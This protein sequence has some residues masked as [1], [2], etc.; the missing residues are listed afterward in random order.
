MG[1]EAKIR[2]ERERERE[3]ESG[4]NFKKPKNDKLIIFDQINL[5]VFQNLISSSA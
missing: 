2:K 5:A 3:R 4:G 1:D